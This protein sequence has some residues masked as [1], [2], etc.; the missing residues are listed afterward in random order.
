M[1]VKSTKQRYGRV[2][3]ILHWMSA[4]FILAMMPL[5]FL[6]QEAGEGAKLPLYR[7]HSAIG[8][9]VL[10]LTV[11]RLAWKTVD[12]RPS[13]P[14]G[15]TGLHLRGMEAIHALLYVILLALT[16][17]G[18]VLNFQSGLI[19]VLRGVSQGTIPEFEKFRARAAHGMLARVYI[20]LLVAHIGGVV[21][22]QFRHGHVFAR[23]GIRRPPHNDSTK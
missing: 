17:S 22:H 19:D 8:L 3:V 2:A 9:V 21:V 23:M 5:G 12:M 4:A 18:I 20:G 13:P 11:I 10:L 15:L 6:M 14:P 16:V 1:A 7:A